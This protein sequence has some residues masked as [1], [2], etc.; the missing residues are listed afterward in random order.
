[1][2]II[3]EALKKAQGYIDD[4]RRTQDR[5]PEHHAFLEKKES[6]SHPRR[7]PIR[8]KWIV[9]IASI[10]L[11]AISGYILQ[12]RFLSKKNS[13][14]R[15]EGA[16]ELV[17]T[18]EGG[19]SHQEVIYKPITKIEPRFE[20]ERAAPAQDTLTS[21]TRPQYP[22]LLLNGIMYLAKKPQAIINGSIVE[23]GDMVS[24]A[25][26]MKIEKNSVVLKFDDT[27]M[28]LSLKK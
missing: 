13:K 10:I 3:Q 7:R 9:A 28:I 11:F 15:A 1:M 8:S 4:Q 18:I 6:A 23:E 2:S 19:A 22:K 16:G 25:T 14:D 17:T 27:E 5:R 24:G 21:D 20:E 12:Q 26:V